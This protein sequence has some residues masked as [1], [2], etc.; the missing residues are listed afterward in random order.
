MSQQNIYQAKSILNELCIAYFQKIHAPEHVE[1]QAQYEMQYAEKMIS[2]S[3]FLTDQE[4]IF[5]VLYAIGLCLVPT[6]E[7]YQQKCMESLSLL[8]PIPI[9]PICLS[10]KLKLRW[11]EFQKKYHEDDFPNYLNVL[12]LIDR[13]VALGY[14]EEALLLA[15]YGIYQISQPIEKVI[16]LF[17]SGQIGLNYQQVQTGVFLIRSA[18]TIEPSLKNQARQMVDQTL[19]LQS[20]GGDDLK[21]LIQLRLNHVDDVEKWA[22]D[23]TA[24][25]IPQ[26]KTAFCLKMGKCIE[27]DLN[28]KREAFYFYQLALDLDLNLNF[29]EKDELLDAMARLAFDELISLEDDTKQAFF[30]DYDLENPNAF[31]GFSTAYTKI[32]QE[33]L[34]FHPQSIILHKYCQ[35]LKELKDWERW[36]DLLSKMI[37]LETDSSIKAKLWAEIALIYL[38]QAKDPSLIHWAIENAYTLD[39]LW[40]LALIAQIKQLPM[41]HTQAFLIDQL[42]QLELQDCENPRIRQTLLKAQALARIELNEI[43]FAYLALMEAWELGSH[44]ALKDQVDSQVVDLIKKLIKREDWRKEIESHMIL[45]FKDQHQDEG[46]VMLFGYLYFQEQSDLCIEIL[47]QALTYQ[48]D[49][50]DLI[51]ALLFHLKQQGKWES[52]IGMIVSSPQHKWPKKAR[53][54]LLEEA[55]AQSK[56]HYPRATSALLRQRAEYLDDLASSESH[57]QSPKSELAKIDQQRFDTQQAGSQQAGSQ[58]AGFQQAGSQQGS[59][60][61]SLEKEKSQSFSKQAKNTSLSTIEIDVDSIEFL[62]DEDTTDVSKTDPNHMLLHLLNQHRLQAWGE[63]LDVHPEDRHALEAY[64]TLARSF[65]EWEVLAKRYEAAI[66]HS[67]VGKVHLYELLGEIYDEILADTQNA[68]RCWSELLLIKSDHLRASR[69]FFELV[70]ALADWDLAYLVWAKLEID[71]QNAKAY[72]E[73]GIR[74]FIGKKQLE[75]AMIQWR[76]LSKIDQSSAHVFVPSL[77]HLA[78]SVAQEKYTIELALSD[79]SSVSQDV[80]I[81]RLSLIANIYIGYGPYRDELQALKYFKEIFYRDQKNTEAIMRITEIFLEIGKKEEML[82]MLDLGLDHLTEQKDLAIFIQNIAVGLETRFEDI[83]EAFHCWLLLLDRCEDSRE[84]AIYH[85]LRMI[86]QHTAYLK[87]VILVLETYLQASKNQ[88]ETALLLR[89]QLSLYSKLENWPQIYQHSLKLKKLEGIS[90]KTIHALTEIAI[91]LA[92][93]PAWLELHEDLV[94]QEKNPVIAKHYL[95]EMAILCESKLEKP[96]QALEYYQK[97]QKISDTMTDTSSNASTDVIADIS[98]DIS[99]LQTRISQPKLPKRPRR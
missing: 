13:I 6:T 54:S 42:I 93:W 83:E 26:Q 41:M 8:A 87:Q 19:A 10:E 91:P 12:R 76:S 52:W 69:R 81:Q 35:I 36:I 40:S 11:I 57:K 88:F 23:L 67:Q 2:L 51:K 72:H 16:L 47:E 68:I 86:K 64:D 5:K 22:Q 56:V 20:V 44:E 75:T 95:N 25:M 61:K 78:T 39:P 98:A 18:L 84:L 80:Q 30:E 94:A 50:W 55:I 77:L 65:G 1:I 14:V 74:I 48:P 4:M 59:K 28:L 63:Y 58:Q 73:A 71:A 97:I 96:E 99:R 27:I 17:E 60:Q 38:S 90:P 79:L 21:A 29:L 32:H 34:F 7:S 92:L 53:K 31:D 89:Y 85:L 82:E 37:E 43:V 33:A 3:S 24:N 70:S 15:Q 62:E 66:S 9:R 45:L 46:S 49:R